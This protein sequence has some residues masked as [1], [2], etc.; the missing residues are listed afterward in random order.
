MGWPMFVPQIIASWG[1]GGDLAL[2]IPWWMMAGMGSDRA[3]EGSDGRDPGG[4]ET[5]EKGGPSYSDR[6]RAPRYPTRHRVQGE[7]LDGQ[8]SI[9]GILDDLSAHGCALHLNTYVPPGTM[10]D[11]RC[12]INGVGLRFRGKVVWAERTGSGALQ[13]VALGDFPS[14]AD[15]LFHRLYVGR[16]AR[17][18]SA[19]PAT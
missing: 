15:A 16:L 8:F 14:E 6:R 9:R 4:Q 2:A 3:A 18:A 11:A 19:P 1:A 12:D 5:A 7:S 17:R 10:I 13:G